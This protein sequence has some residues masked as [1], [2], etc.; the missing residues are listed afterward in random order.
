MIEK[1]GDEVSYL[2]GEELARWMDKESKIIAATE[3]ELVKE[4]AQKK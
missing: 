1:P 4:A 3:A 2:N